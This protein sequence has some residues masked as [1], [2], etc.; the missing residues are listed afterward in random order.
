MKNEPF[1][2][3]ALMALAMQAV[4]AGP[5]GEEARLLAI[6]R[7]QVWFGQLAIRA[8]SAQELEHGRGVE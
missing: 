2:V 1:L 8:F 3:G 4:H 6:H 5:T 7:N